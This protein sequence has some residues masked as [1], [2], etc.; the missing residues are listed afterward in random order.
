MKT[1]TILNTTSF[2]ALLS[3]LALVAC[4]GSEVE[5]ADQAQGA[6]LT[7]DAQKTPAPE[8]MRD[9]H[10]PGAR[11][12]R[13]GEHRFGPPSP[14]KMLERLDANK[15]GQL[16]AAELPERMQQRIAEIDTSGDAVVTKA[17]LEAHFNAKQAEH[18][19]KFAE[20]AKARF[21]EKDANHDG[22][23]EQTE[24]GEHWAKL[25]V[26]DAN[27]DQKLTPEELKTAFEAG[28]LKPMRGEHGRHFRG[29][30]DAPPTQAPAA[31]T[32]PTL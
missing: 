7:Q 32:T 30:P 25:S 5:P 16:E 10:H 20:R 2:A 27:G 19:A 6:A 18:R 28:K 3:S 22:M 26:A 1:S 17:E 4:G 29:G 14:D 31:P 15:N 24:V 12:E 11:G 9:G 8:A 13:H 21:D 23:L